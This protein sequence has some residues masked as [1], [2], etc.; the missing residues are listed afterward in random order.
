MK[1]TGLLFGIFSVVFSISS[2]FSYMAMHDIFHDYVSKK[3]VKS[4][5]IPLWTD[6]RGEWT[7]VRI[8]FIIRIIF[9]IILLISGI[10]RMKRAKK[11]PAT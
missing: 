2:V 3:I 8:D 11:Y 10:R 5:D 7:V 9:L 6:C 1:K 4:A